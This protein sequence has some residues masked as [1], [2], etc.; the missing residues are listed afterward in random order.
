MNIDATIIDFVYDVPVACCAARK[1]GPTGV[2]SGFVRIS[3]IM[4]LPLS[5]C[6][7]GGGVCTAMIKGVTLAF[8]CTIGRHYRTRIMG[9]AGG[10]ADGGFSR[11]A[12]IAAV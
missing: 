2:D 11:G 9:G 3:Y 4:C 6:V 5:L 10:A 7:G 1:H 12:A 8:F